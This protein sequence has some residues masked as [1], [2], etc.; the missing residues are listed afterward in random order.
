MQ[1]KDD[2]RDRAVIDDILES[3]N[4][5][6]QFIEGFDE[7]SFIVDE[8]THSS[9]IHRLLVIGEAAKRLSE[10]TKNAYPEVPWKQIM[11]M[12]DRLIHGYHEVDLYEVWGTARIDAPRLIDLLSRRI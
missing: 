8:K 10:Q 6:A 3:C 12:R 7:D 2:P 5:I 4:L 11:G 1:S 9:V